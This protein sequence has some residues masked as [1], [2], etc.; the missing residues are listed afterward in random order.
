MVAAHALAQQGWQAH[1]DSPGGRLCYNLLQ[2]IEAKSIDVSIE[3]VWNNPWPAIHLNYRNLTKVH[4]RAIRYDWERLVK[5][6]NYYPMRVDPQL[7]RELLA[8]QP[9]LQWSHDLPPTEDYLEAQEHFTVPDDLKP[10]FYYL[11]ASTD[12]KFGDQD[13][14]V[15]VQEFWVSPLSIVIRTGATSGEVDGFVLDADTGEPLPEAQVRAWTYQRNGRQYRWVEQQPVSTDRNGQFRIQGSGSETYLLLAKHGRDSLATGSQLRAY[16]VRSERKP[17]EQTIF[18]TDRALYRPGQTIHFKGILIKVDQQQ[19]QYETLA[20]KKVTVAFLD[21]N[22]QEI[23]K[24][25]CQTNDYGS[26]SGSFTAPQDRLTGRMQLRDITHGGL[27]QFNV[28]QYKRP[29]FKVELSSPTTAARLGG[30]VE[31]PGTAQAYT[32]ATIGGARVTYRVVR[33]VRYPPWWHWLFWWN[34]PQAQEQ[35]IASGTTVTDNDGT[36][37][38]PFMARPDPSVAEKD[39]PTFHFTIYADVTDT[40]GETRSDQRSVSIGYTDLQAS[41]SADTWQTADHDVKIRLTTQ[42]LDS[43]P[44]AAKG[45]LKIYSLQQP[46]QVHRE[47]LA[48][49]RPRLPRRGSGNGAPASDLSNMNSWPLGPLAV[50]QSFATDASG[51]TVATCQLAAGP[52]RAIL[53]T[54]DSSGKAVKAI[55]PLQVLDPQAEHFSIKIPNFVGAPTWTVEPGGSFT[56]LWGTGYEAGRAFVEVEH[57]GKVL[58]SYWTRPGVT[59]ATL[60]Q[61]VT[62]AM[63]GGFTLRVTPGAREPCVSGVASCQRAVD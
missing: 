24:Q 13:N 30:D 40:T 34:P 12:E 10:G 46:D 60:E 38:I 39:E 21:A 26:F 44:R 27:T 43:Q 15:L 35:E 20:G 16:V 6:V 57:R 54:Q 58:Q 1:G 29:K 41:M 23:S 56:S 3:R 32:G 11:L 7:R 51:V 53:E 17:Y 37:S 48:F 49:F 5:E 45:S 59:Q 62:E 4:F 8:K 14:R 61:S 28:E 52:Y 19:D 42:S 63:R 31:V 36:F 9:T 25:D 55:L 2:S 18:F 50:E 47:R 33:A 22:Q